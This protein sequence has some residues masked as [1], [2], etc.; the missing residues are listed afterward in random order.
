MILVNLVYFVESSLYE[1][2]QIYIDMEEFHNHM[3]RLGGV[4]G[5]FFHPRDNRP[6]NG[7]LIDTD[8][9]AYINQINIV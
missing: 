6:I 4:R 9:M 3:K 1:E 7:Y 8:K 2:V 5:S